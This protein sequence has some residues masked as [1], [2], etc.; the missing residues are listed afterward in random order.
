MIQAIP[1]LSIYPEKTIVQ[2]DICILKFIAAL[3]TIAR[4]WKQAKC[5]SAEVWIKKM[6]YR[7]IIEYY[8]T[9]KRNEVMPFAEK[10][11]DLVI[12]IQSEVC[13]KE[14]N[15]CHVKLPVGGIKKKMVHVNLF[16]KQK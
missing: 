15:N 7:C 12:V 4:T 11:M 13:Q 6:W 8:R 1:L 16:A 9:V 3:S 14:K 2:K 10:W 5:R